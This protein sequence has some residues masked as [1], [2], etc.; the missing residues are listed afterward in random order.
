MSD[1]IDFLKFLGAALGLLLSVL[2][3]FGAVLFSIQYVWERDACVTYSHQTGFPFSYTWST[4][5]LLRTPD[6]RWV[7]AESY[8]NNV[9]DVKAK[10]Q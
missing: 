2:C 6:G 1:T 5:C 10:V 9:Q 8:L 3:G 4:A 7:N